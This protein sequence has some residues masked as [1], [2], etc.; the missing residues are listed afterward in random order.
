[1]SLQHYTPRNILVT[2]GAGFIGANFIRYYLSQHSQATLVNLDLLTYAGSLKNLENLPAPSRYHFVEGDIG[3]SALIANIL[4]EYQIDTIVHFAAE[5]HVDR[6]IQGPTPFIQTNVVGT[7]ILLEAARQFWLHEKKW[8]ATQCRFHHIS[9]DEV[10]GSLDKRDPAFTEETAY[11]PN[12]PYSASKAGSDHLVRAY[13]HTY[14]LPVTMSNCSNNYGP[15]QHP[16]KFIPT[17]IRHCIEEKPI[18]VY[19]DGSNIRDWLYVE[20]H[21]QGIDKILTQGRIGESYNLG[22]EYE[23]DNLSLAKMI[24][25]M[26]DKLFPR[27]ESYQ[28]LISF[29]TD[30]PGHD[31]RYAIDISKVS[32]ELGWKPIET[33]ES[34]IIK[35]IQFYC[36]VIS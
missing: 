3:D 20:D 29:V 23:V 5:S 7:F 32:R 18:P 6:S 22:G 17:I 33:F 16:E 30:R 13:F 36:A 2:G 15:Y 25:K 28:T 1:M 26:F 8:D 19:G 21:C 9:T 10:Y 14:H 24:C 31:W 12:S 35:T 11:A 34:G 27:N 4:R